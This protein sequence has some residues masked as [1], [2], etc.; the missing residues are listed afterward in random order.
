MASKLNILKKLKEL[1]KTYF[2]V[3]ELSR[4]LGIKRPSIDTILS[5]L[6]KAGVL[7]RA[8]RGIYIVLGSP[9]ELDKM[10]TQIFRPCYI[11]FETALS[12]YGII[13]Q[14]PYSVTLASSKGTKK[15]T[16]CGRSIEISKIKKSL[17]FGYVMEGG[18]LIATPEKALLDM[19]YMVSLGKSFFDLSELDLK[20]ISKKKI[21]ELSKKYPK[22]TQRLLKRLL[23]KYRK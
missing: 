1:K 20:D 4:I 16:L 10:A 2:T 15:I 7:Q 13:D 5:R 21:L 9:I 6:V 14:I 11:S 8:G 22:A 23:R 17:F 19:L 18:V 3:N 12:R